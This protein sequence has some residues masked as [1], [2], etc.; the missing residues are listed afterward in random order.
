MTTRRLLIFRFWFRGPGWVSA[1]SPLQRDRSLRLARSR[2]P[3]WRSPT[4]EVPER[5]NPGRLPK[6]GWFRSLDGQSYT[7][8]RVHLLT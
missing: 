7:C 3:A 5:R 1:G 2:E 6:Q 4:C 8:E